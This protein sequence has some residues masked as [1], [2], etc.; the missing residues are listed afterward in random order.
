MPTSAP[1]D[2]RAFRNALGSF[3][4]GVTIVTARDRSGAD[5]GLTANSFNSVS[6]DPPMVLWSLG[7]KSTNLD[8]FLAAEHFAVHILA[9]DQDRLS[10]LFATSGADKFAGLALSRG[11]GGVPLI[12]GCS[13]CFECRTA[14]RYEGGDHVIFVGEVLSFEHSDRPPLVFHGGRYATVA[15]R[16]A[17]PEGGFDEDFL[18]HLLMRA[19]RKLIAPLDKALDARGLDEGDFDALSTLG[20][21]GAIRAGVLRHLA[22]RDLVS[23]GTL[24]GEG[25]EALIELAA[26][27][28]DAEATVEETLDH[29]EMLLLKNLLRRVIGGT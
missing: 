25:R 27:A 18:G 21:G 1:A 17:A 28:K 24:T 29:G 26:A 14:Y 9:A 20:S 8:A 13:A 15:R 4:T 16:V 22:E 7:R 5:V 23:K 12:G 2:G 11:H 3:T 19:Y 10:T 6:L